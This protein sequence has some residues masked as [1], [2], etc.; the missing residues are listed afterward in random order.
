MLWTPLPLHH[1]GGIS[2]AF[3]CWSVGATYVHTG[4]FVPDVAVRQL[5]DEGA[6][7]AI[8]AFEM[9]WLAVV[10]HDDF[11]AG[12]LPH[13]R[14]VFNI[15]SPERLRQ[16]QARVPNAIQ[17]SGFGATEATSFMTLGEVD[18]S[19][20]DRVKTIGRPLPGLRVRIVDPVGG[21][22]VAAA[23]V[24]GFLIR[25][26]DI[27]I[28]HVVAAPDARYGEVAAAYVEL[29]KGAEVTEQEIID[30][31]LGSIATFKVPRY[32][33]FIDEWPMSGTKVKKYVLREMIAAELGS[34]GITEAPRLTAPA[35]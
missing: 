16:L 23:E 20:D 28:A 7:I 18:D 30:F 1:I 21:E 22:N 10:E 29:V 24:E 26:D 31:C 34:A 6:T 35:R 8:P 4:H 9:I 32:V 14:L 13:L 3:A 33:R 17:V 25:H 12:D 19:L 27:A 5:R 2:F 15:G 11:D